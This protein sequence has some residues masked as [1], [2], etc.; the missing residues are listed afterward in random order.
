MHHSRCSRAH[1][2]RCLLAA[3]ACVA[4]VVH[5]D[6]VTA[7]SDA[8]RSLLQLLW[9]GNLPPLP[10][11][12]GNRHA[13]ET[14]AAVL[15]HRLFFDRRL[16][17]NGEVS[18]A[19]CHVPDLFFTDGLPRG[20]GI[21]ETARNTPGIVGGAYSPWLFWDGR[22]DSLW[23]QALVPLETAEEHGGNRSRYARILVS[24][25]VYRS[26]YNSVFGGLPDLSDTA[27]F[28]PDASPFATGKARDDWLAMRED[29]R[30]S[31]NRVFANLGKALE[32]YQRRLVPGRSRFDD[33]VESLLDDRP[34]DALSADEIAGLKL[35]IGRAKC[36]TCHLGPL[37][38]NH[39]FHNVATPDPS[40]RKPDYLPG[41]VYLFMDKPDP[42]RGRYDGVRQALES[43]FNCLGEYSDAQPSDCAELSFAATDHRTTLGAFK[44]PSLRNVSRTAPYTHAGV[45]ATLGEVLDH[46]N[47]PPDA[48]VGHSELQPLHLDERE[49]AQL[50]AFLHSLDSTADAPAE[51]LESPFQ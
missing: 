42:D 8:E 35:F 44:V 1:V 39:A 20:R 5:A 33:F 32:A 6:P 50:E 9:I 46:Y 19:T 10:P 4:G 30:K 37:F 34:S 36:V 31:V 28:P 11:S 13:D 38:T 15:G 40:A 22:R 41:I 26:I 49:L 12:P 47:E 14:D 21:G 29:D 45:F 18:C 7:W 3:L 16:S 48:P 27:R 25:P 2:A 24:D 51:L 43:E 17:V 23:S